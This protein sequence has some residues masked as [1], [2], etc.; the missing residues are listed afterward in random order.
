[1]KAKVKG[2]PTDRKIAFSSGSENYTLDEHI[3]DNF[4][5]IE[6][7]TK[8]EVSEYLRSLHDRRIAKAA[9]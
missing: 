5:P 4:D 2:V 6:G 3:K 7:V 1:M 8:Q 9:A